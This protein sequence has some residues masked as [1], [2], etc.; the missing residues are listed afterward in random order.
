MLLPFCYLYKSVLPYG[1]GIRL[2][3]YVYD[4][5]ASIIK[6]WMSKMKNAGTI[7]WMAAC[8]S[9]WID[10]DGEN[11]RIYYLQWNLPNLNPFYH[12]S[13]H[14]PRIHFMIPSQHIYV[15]IYIYVNYMWCILRKHITYI[16][17]C[18]STFIY[19]TESNT[20]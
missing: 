13:F 18:K 16:I 6:C 11:L 3:I 12:F 2:Y 10:S 14:F 7:F 15:P 1:N 4:R 20:K 17:L 19:N 9:P 8:R 5:I